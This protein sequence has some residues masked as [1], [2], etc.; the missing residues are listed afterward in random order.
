MQALRR[1]TS[2]CSLSFSFGMR[3]AIASLKTTLSVR[4][5]SPRSVRACAG[6]ISRIWADFGELRPAS[7]SACKGLRVD[8]KHALAPSTAFRGH[9]AMRMETQNQGP[10]ARASAWRPA[11][12]QGAE[13]NRHADPACPVLRR[14]CVARSTARPPAM[15]PGLLAQ[16]RENALPNPRI[17]PHPPNL[18]TR[19]KG[20]KRGMA[21]KPPRVCQRWEW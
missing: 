2:N 3:S 6:P 18:L 8:P 15:W 1:V 7:R 16:G 10:L 9:T 11:A 13:E 12:K 5:R 4:N 20:R 17:A 21:D 19:G 14:I